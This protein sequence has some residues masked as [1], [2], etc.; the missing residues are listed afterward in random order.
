MV[1]PIVIVDYDPTW[2]VVFERLKARAQSVLGDLAVEIEHVG[3]TSIPGAAAKPIIDM[4]VVVA[5]PADISMAVERL[6]M[7]GY[8]H[9]G[10][11]GVAGR[12][13][14]RSPPGF[15]PHH[16]YVCL[17]DGRE[18]RRH[19]AFRDHLRAHPEKVRAYVA[20]KREA[21]AH[22]RC[23]RDGYTRAKT[24][25]VEEMLREADGPAE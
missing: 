11:L 24:T 1:E 2:P 14:F 25:F 7:L 19:L 23:N 22:F 5:S 16:L 20:M 21:A 18:Y 4:D 6:A 9:Q 10:D 13:A 8:V 12:E 15:P 3:S 17:L